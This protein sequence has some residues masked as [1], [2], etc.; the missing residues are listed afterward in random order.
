LASPLR[1]GGIHYDEHGI[2]RTRTGADWNAIVARHEQ[3]RQAE[4][5]AFDK[6]TDE[7]FQQQYREH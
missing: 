3:K 1:C 2:P 5:A 7:E 6:L 4:L